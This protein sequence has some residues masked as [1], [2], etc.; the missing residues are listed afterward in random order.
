MTPEQEASKLRRIAR[1]IGV[2]E[3]VIIDFR[4]Q[5]ISDE[6]VEILVR[7][8]VEIARISNSLSLQ[9]SLLDPSLACRLSKRGEGVLW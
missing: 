6:T 7:A 8:D 5:Q 3:D 2:L 9:A 1:A 4:G